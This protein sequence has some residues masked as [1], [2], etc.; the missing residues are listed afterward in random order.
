MPGET[1][2]RYSIRIGSSPRPARSGWVLA[3]LAAIA[4]AGCASTAPTS[5]DT[6]DQPPPI[7][8]QAAAGLP[9]EYVSI[10]DG[11]RTVQR[12][13]IETR[14]A[15]APNA[16][17]LLMVQTDRDGSNA[18]RFGLQLE[19]TDVD[20]RLAGNFAILDGRG[21]SRRSCPMR[22]HVT[23]EGLVG[24]TDPES[25][26][27]GEGDEAVGV[28]K[29]IAFGGRR[30]TIADRLVDPDSQASLGAD[31]VIRFL[32]AVEFSGWLGVRESS[33]W[34]VAREFSIRVGQR[35]EPLDAA[36]MSLGLALALDYYRMEREDAAPM[37]RLTVVD[38]ES[39]EVI[40][41]SWAEPGSGSIGLAL[42][43]LQVGL[44]P[45]D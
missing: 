45:P 5:D 17:G 16:L 12:L 25:C 22:F 2:A 15:T 30:I 26:E 36:D 35:L 32:P 18:R 41:E 21:Q 7:L 33:D 27:F 39:G 19:P 11:D 24:E 10:R 37:L 4:L 44:Q 23:G 42:E 9:G 8:R 38:A 43:E 31:Q 14:S 20:H 3:A 28:L 29:E 34:R 13:R 1:E 40:A 6:R